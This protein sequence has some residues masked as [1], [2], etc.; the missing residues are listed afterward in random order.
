[1]PSTG[2]SRANQLL[3]RSLA[4]ELRQS[5]AD[6]ARRASASLSAVPPPSPLHALRNARPCP[7]RRACAAGTLLNRIHCRA[8]APRRTGNSAAKHTRPWLRSTTPSR[9]RPNRR[10][11]RRRAPS[12][13]ARK[14]RCIIAVMCSACWKRLEL[15]T[16]RR[17]DSSREMVRNVPIVSTHASREAPP[18]TPRTPPPPP[19]VPHV[20]T[21]VVNRWSIRSDN[22]LPVSSRC[23]LA[24]SVSRG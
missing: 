9:S 16:V 6:D 3:L 12:A 21:R 10:S 5:A 20:C 1:M 8:A 18:P 19:P 24:R 17:D 13:A 4:I 11:P 22:L 2:R 14:L 23:R 15:Q 7:F